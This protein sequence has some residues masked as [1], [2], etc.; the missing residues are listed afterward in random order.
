[1]LRRLAADTIKG[2]TSTDG[3]AKLFE[4]GFDVV[5]NTPEEFALMIR[6]QIELVGKILKSTGMK[7]ADS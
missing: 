4:A 3:R 1:V 2:I 7:L 6:N 5:G